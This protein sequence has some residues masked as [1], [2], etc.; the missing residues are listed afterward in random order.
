VGRQAPGL[1]Q[2]GHGP[3]PAAARAASPR[4]ARPRWGCG[5]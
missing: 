5:R 2:A 3:T 4:R 1:G